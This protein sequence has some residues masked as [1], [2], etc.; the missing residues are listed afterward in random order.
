MPLFI[1]QGER[2]YQAT[3]EDFGIWKDALAG[4]ANVQMKSYPDLN[5][6][7]ISGEVKSTPTEYQT[8]GNVSAIIIQD[9]AAW[10]Q[11]QKQR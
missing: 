3:M 6:L 2:D 9:V 7:F 11:Q 5:H 4:R 1:V 8:P 10:I